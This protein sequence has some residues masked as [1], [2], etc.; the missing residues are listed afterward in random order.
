MFSKIVEATGFLSLLQ[1]GRD[2]EA[3]FKVS[4]WGSAENNTHSSDQGPDKSQKPNKTDKPDMMNKPDYV[5]PERRD[6]SSVKPEIVRK[7]DRTR[8]RAENV[9]MDKDT[10]AED[11]LSQQPQV[12]VSPEGKVLPSQDVRSECLHFTFVGSKNENAIL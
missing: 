11:W 7:P 10:S 8:I 9:D 6:R 3:F 5:K 12:M 1:P 4:A 2:Y